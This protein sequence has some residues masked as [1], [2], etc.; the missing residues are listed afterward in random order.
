[1][2]SINLIV[3][4]KR[5]TSV[6]FF[7]VSVVLAACSSMDRSS[8]IKNH[9]L[10]VNISKK[11]DVVNAIGLPRRIESGEIDGSEVWFY[12]GKPIS[13]SYFVPVP[14]AAVPATSGLTTVFY[15]NAGSQN[16]I[17]NEP[18]VL[19]LIFNKDGLLVV[20]NNREKAK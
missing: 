8:D 7:V 10:G 16:V 19:A 14:V 17:E 6:F 18:V 11:T 3:C 9:R 5:M 1:M 12:T 15:L 13:T 4:S 20:I 2:S